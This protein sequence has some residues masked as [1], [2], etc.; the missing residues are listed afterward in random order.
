M[1][2]NRKKGGKEGLGYEFWGVEDMTL[3]DT[4]GHKLYPNPDMVLLVQVLALMITLLPPLQDACAVH[5][6]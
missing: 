2:V 6:W 5:P 4:F 1:V 3:P